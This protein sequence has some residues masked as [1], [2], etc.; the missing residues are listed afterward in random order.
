MPE[1]DVIQVSL[2]DGSVKTMEEIERDVIAYALAR[3]CG[4][5]A[6]AARALGIGRSTFYRK[7]GAVAQTGERRDGIAEAGD[8]IA[9]CSTSSKAYV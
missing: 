3:C 8:S 4:N 6:A 9:P 7:I 1:P 5:K 2:P